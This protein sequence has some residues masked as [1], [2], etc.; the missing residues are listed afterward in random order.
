MLTATTKPSI[1][2]ALV[3]LLL[4]YAALHGAWTV[5]HWG[6]AEVVARVAGSPMV[7]PG[8]VAAALAFRR[9]RNESQSSARRG[10]G[11]LAFALTLYSLGL[12][13]WA[14]YT[15]TYASIPFPSVAD[16]MFLVF[17]W[18]FFA[19][20]MALTYEQL[21]TLDHRRV[22]LNHDGHARRSRSRGVGTTTAKHGSG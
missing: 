20:L 5:F 8:W 19:S 2:L 11:L 7:L 4:A 13:L 15:V 18:I 10:W 17:P 14:Y 16:P 3:S 9:A 6:G 12:V 22:L 21:S 1:R